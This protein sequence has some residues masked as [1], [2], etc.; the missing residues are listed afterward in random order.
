[1]YQTLKPETP[2]WR[3]MLMQSPGVPGVLLNDT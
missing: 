2:K 3:P 1:M